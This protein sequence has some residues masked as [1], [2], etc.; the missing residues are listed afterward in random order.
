[1]LLN[2]PPPELGKKILAQ[3]EHTITAHEKFMV[4]MGRGSGKTSYVECATLFAIATG[5]QKFV[6]VV[7]AN[8]RASSNILKDIW[9]AVNEK[10]TA[11]AQDYPEIAAPFHIANGSLRRRQLYR[12][13]STDLER[14]SSELVFA[15]LK[16]EHGNEMPTS[17]SV[18]SCRGVT[19]GIRGLK[20]GNLRPSYAILDDIMTAKDARSPEA[21]EKLMDAINKDIIPLSGK[22]RL[23]VLQTATPIAPDDLVEKIKQDKSWRTTIFP[24]VISFPKNSAL[25]DEYFK[26]WDDENVAETGHAGSLGFYKEHRAEMDEG[27]EVFNPTRFSETDGHISAIQKLLE[28][29]HTLGEAVFLSEY[30]MSPRAMQFALPITPKLVASRVSTLGELE[31]PQEGVQYICASTDINASKY[32][33]TVIMVF[34]RNQTS[35]IIWHKFRRCRIPAN[36]PEHDYYQ[37]LYNLLGEHGRELK[38]LADEHGFKIQGWSI[39]C[40][41]TNWN[42]VLDFA[43]NSIRICGLPCCG[44][45]GKASH[46]YRSFMRSRLKEDVNRTLLCGDED[47]RKKS[48]TGRRWMYFDSDMSHEQAQKGFIQEVG[49]IGSISWY[50]DGNHTEMAV[51]VCNEKLIFK[52]ARQDGTVEYTWKEIGEDHDALDAI[53]QCLATYASQGFAT[54]A[55]GKT[56]LLASRQRMVKRKVRFV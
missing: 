39:D 5:R 40:G 3:M 37:R 44:F 7:S 46:A 36:I 43:K 1:M 42:A 41:G 29:Q 49:N 13:V 22:E 9:R 14:N 34:M 48:G 12:G 35:H 54:G 8:Q 21:I 38:Q 18:I 52:H 51:Q 2:D 55:S 17:G 19:S 16:D 6:V 33:T 24:A 53:G 26:M 15:R 23:S 30:Q 47:E 31:V 45:A 25:W 56:S 20:R 10:G 4:C 28:L 27:A 11:F 32:L 50:K